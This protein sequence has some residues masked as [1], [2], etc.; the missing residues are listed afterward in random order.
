MK[1]VNQERLKQS[2]QKT[3]ITGESRVAYARVEIPTVTGIPE[4]SLREYQ[5]AGLIPAPIFLWGELFYTGRQ[6][7]LL[8]NAYTRQVWGAIQ[9]QWNDDDTA[10]DI[11]PRNQ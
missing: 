6:L 5:E 2:R 3:T 4:R 7:T 8:Y 10:E 9:K 11:W 1:T